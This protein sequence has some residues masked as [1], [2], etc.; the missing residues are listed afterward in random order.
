MANRPN[1]FQMLLVYEYECLKELDL[2]KKSYLGTFYR[3]INKRLTAKSGVGPLGHAGSG[4]ITETGKSKKA[5]ML[6][7]YFKSVFVP[8]DGLLPYFP[9]RVSQDI[10]I[11]NIEVTADR[12]LYF[13]N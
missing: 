3:F 8:D 9:S 6:N 5:S 4:D 13:I 7:E 12:V 2:I 10:F 11:N 1:I